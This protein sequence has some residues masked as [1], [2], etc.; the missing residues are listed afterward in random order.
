MAIDLSQVAQCR[1]AQGAIIKLVQAIQGA[2]VAAGQDPVRLEAIR[3][4]LSDPRQEPGFAHLVPDSAPAPEATDPDLA[5][6]HASE[7]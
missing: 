3:A 4:Q 1:S 7:F 5:D 6:M 2:L